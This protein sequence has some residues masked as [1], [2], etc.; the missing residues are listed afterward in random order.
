MMRFIPSTVLKLHSADPVWWTPESSDAIN[1]KQ[2]AWKRLCLQAGHLQ[3]QRSYKQATSTASACIR[4]AEDTHIE[5][6]RRILATGGLSSREW[7]SAV[8]RAGGCGRSQEIPTLRDSDGT[9]HTSSRDKAES[10]ARY[11]AAKCSLDNNL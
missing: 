10:F 8:K 6:I 1:S 3:L 11:F 5:A 7:W 2:K 4:R 9:E